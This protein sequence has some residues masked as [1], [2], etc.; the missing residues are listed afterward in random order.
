MPLRYQIFGKADS[1]TD[2][3]LFCDVED[4]LGGLDVTAITND[5]AREVL[6]QNGGIVEIRNPG[7]IVISRFTK[8]SSF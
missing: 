3:E 6:Q 1:A 2:F 5:I 7:G 4:S 8:K